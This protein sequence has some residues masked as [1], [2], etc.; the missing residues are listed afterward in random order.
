MPDNAAPAS[1]MHRVFAPTTHVGKP[2][3]MAVRRSVGALGDDGG[4]ALRAG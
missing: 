1:S 4:L 3:S 2:L